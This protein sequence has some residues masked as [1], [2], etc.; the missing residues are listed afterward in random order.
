MISRFARSRAV[1]KYLRT[2]SSSDKTTR[3][4]DA[5]KLRT[6]RGLALAI[7]N[8]IFHRRIKILRDEIA[9]M[10]ISNATIFLSFHEE[11]ERSEKFT[12]SRDLDSLQSIL[13][14]YNWRRL[15]LAFLWEYVPRQEHSDPTQRKRRGRLTHRYCARRLERK[16][17]IFTT[18]GRKIF[19]LAGP[20]K[21]QNKIVCLIGSNSFQ[22]II[23]MGWT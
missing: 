1:M 13:F 23:I 8:H 2:T 6:C 3:H 17:T 15:F 20:S 14:R 18:V 21:N 10:T 16:I 12:E 5:S 19:K 11:E 7:L 22:S 4:G 9:T